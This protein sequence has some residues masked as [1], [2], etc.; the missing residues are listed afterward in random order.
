MKQIEIPTYELLKKKEKKS[1]EILYLRYGRK[2]MYYAKH[3]WNINEDEAT[4]LIY[5]TLY[6]IIE[7]VENYKFTSEEKFGSFV[8]TV[9]INYLKNLHRDK[10]NREKYLEEVEIAEA[11][12]N[13][14]ST[15]EVSPDD[16]EEKFTSQNLQLLNEELD[17]LQEWERMV[18]LLRAQDMPYSEIAKFVNKPEDQLKVYYKRLK[19]KLTERLNERI[20]KN[21]M[22]HV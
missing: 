8:F 16:Q 6:K 1:I 17:K 15:N 19:T 9:F 20:M 13:V 12:L 22:Q 4:D 2:L 11:D 3:T 7:S 18:L 10:K 14:L 21:T 5:K